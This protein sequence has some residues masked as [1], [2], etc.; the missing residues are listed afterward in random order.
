VTSPGDNHNKVGSN[1]V[2]A[3]SDNVIDFAEKD[4]NENDISYEEYVKAH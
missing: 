4:D 2:Q 1:L 3:Q